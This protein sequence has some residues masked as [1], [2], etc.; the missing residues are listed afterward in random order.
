MARET[1]CEESTN[2]AE[3]A[4][5]KTTDGKPSPTTP[6]SHESLNPHS[7]HILIV[8]DERIVATQIEHLLTSFGYTAIESVPTG[9]E[10]L[11]Q[12]EGQLPDLI[13]MDIELAGE[14]DGV[15]TATWIQARFDV[16]IVYLSA[17]PERM[18]EDAGRTPFCGFLSKPVR[19]QELRA[20]IQMALSRYQLETRLHESETK[21]RLL[22]ENVVDVIW[23]V[24]ETLDGYTYVSPSI[25]HLLGYTPEE[26]KAMPLIEHLVPS[27]RPQA[28]RVLERLM[29]A[30]GENRGDET[31]RVWEA[32]CVRKDGTTVWCESRVQPLRGADG[33]FCGL[34]GVTRDVSEQK[35]YTQELQLI[36]DAIVRV[37]RMQNLDR[38]CKFIGETVHAVNEEGSVIVTLYDNDVDAIRIR[39][40][41]GFDERVERAF[42]LL[43]LD[44]ATIQIRRE[45]MGEEARLYTTG[46]LERVSLYELAAGR[47]PRAACS[48]V[49]RLLD[50]DT[51]HTVGFGLA[52]EAYGGVTILL[53]KGQKIRCRS[54]IETLASHLS[55]TIQRRRAEAASRESEARL[56]RIVEGTEAMLVNV[57]ARGRIT[58]VNDAAATML[59]HSPEDLIGKSYL[60]FVHP[61]D[62]DRVSRAYQE[63]AEKEI[64]STS[65]TFRIVTPSGAVRWV[66]FVA[67]PIAKGRM[68][69][70][71]LDITERKRAEEALQES[72]ALYRSLVETAPDAITLTDLEGTI[73]LCNRQT[74]AMHGFACAKGVVGESAFA[75]IAPQ[76]RERAMA[77]AA[78]V[79]DGEAVKLVEYAMLKQDGTRFLAEL[80]A[81]LIRDAQGNPKAFIGVS[82][83]ITERK[84]IE[85]ELRRLIAAVQTTTDSIVICDREGKIVYANPASYRLHRLDG[86]DELIGAN[87]FEWFVPEEQEKAL[88]AMQ[89]V[90]D[91]GSITGRE[92]T[93]LTKDGERV[94]IEISVTV[95]RDDE[96]EPTEFAGV[97]RDITERKR[98][99]EKLRATESLQRTVIDSLDEAL[100][101]I[102]AECRIRLVNERFSEW[103][104]QLGLERGVLGRRLQNVFPFLSDAVMDQYRGVFKTGVPLVT[105]EEMTF[106]D[107]NGNGTIVTETRK[108]PVKTGEKVTGVLT[109]IADITERKRAE[110]AL[111]AS[112][113]RLLTI[114]DGIDADIYVA[115]M[116]TYE[117]L[118]LNQHMRT[119]FGENLVGKI[120]WE[121]FRDGAG[122]CAHCTNDP[123][124]DADGNPSGVLV[125]EGQNP[126]TGNWYINYDRAIRWMDGR[127]VRL[128]IATDIS[129]RKRA[130]E[131]LQESNL[132]LEKALA[133]L[134]EA[135]ETM[136][137]QARLAAVGQLSAGI[138]HDFR[139][140]LSTIILYAQLC[141]SQ[142]DVSPRVGQ[143]IE[144]IIDESKKA[145][146]LVQQI[147]DFS[148]RSMLRTQV[149]DL[150]PL[151]QDVM[152]ILQHTI[153][154]H[155]RLSLEMKVDGSAEDGQPFMVR[156]DPARI[157]QA[158]TNL[159]LNARDAMPGGGA[160][161]F[162]LSCIEVTTDEPL[163]IA[164]SS[165]RA[166]VIEEGQWI[167]LIVS[168]T[169]IGMTAEVRD[170]LFEPFFTTK[171]VDEGTGLGLAQVYGIVRQHG[172]YID[173][174]TELGQGTTFRIY[175][176]AYQEEAHVD[177]DAVSKPKSEASLSPPEG[178]GE[179]ILL[180]ED[181]EALREAER[182]MLESL[183]YRVLTAA[184]GGEALALC[185]SPRWSGDPPR[186]QVDLVITD[187]VMPEMGGKELVR[188]LRKK[189]PSLGALGIT[190]Y[191]GEAVTEVL[192]EVGFL[193]V[194]HKPFEMEALA[195]VIRQALSTD[196]ARK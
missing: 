162:E 133:D 187:M 41:I 141:Q 47:L 194:I 7:C 138:A 4:L 65:I 51:V 3:P 15:E 52:D 18:E 10:A 74:A 186:R 161:R 67:H 40:M 46:K 105:Q 54:M 94:P 109:I 20:A 176:P 97:T 14:L 83:D 190:G 35:R 64:P 158:L 173:V 13:L 183:G 57:D 108:I 31:P 60:R 147:L 45:E 24:N 123:L 91:A 146:D 30:E 49:K 11:R 39:A 81:S 195:R 8:E 102:N 90:L 75:L 32:K 1:T 26:M 153:P 120:C 92:F 104:E 148:G 19:R 50:I 70:L 96:G 175:L 122:P 131:A 152:D 110:E 180:V 177:S 107:E 154:E 144:T 128:Q 106:D 163:P 114:L 130:E 72:E 193:D 87:V 38:T 167:C 137:Q 179:T 6:E 59:E 71:A 28:Q 142:L 55:V 25:T 185:Q 73:Q 111:R 149:V 78:R 98:A 119:S 112:H 27:S 166:D 125:W 103:T 184:N 157:Q 61:E 129:E 82:R 155:I 80:S 101:L 62:R 159:A 136:L 29:S 164:A 178:Q 165:P 2:P 86:E 100:H 9:E 189:N 36:T 145:A 181:E 85:Q 63:Q 88:A 118:F 191:S 48:V 56:R 12:V 143:H 89:E 43:G 16:P 93:T 116:E 117:V 33:A 23:Q 156:V 17:Y 170:H 58:Y 171:D 69:G 150:Q 134:Q 34:V 95:L 113:Q 76:D 53:P 168:D 126:I 124:I 79:L 44:P 66:N 42:N 140:L 151:T 132:R 68:A 135:Q 182:E 21:Y 174:E 127:L 121:V 172:G 188:E 160:L 192:R 99:E 37:S 196:T 169:G 22:A 139:N 77:N 115:D 84:R 5:E